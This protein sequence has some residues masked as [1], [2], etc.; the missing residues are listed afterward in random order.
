MTSSSV[1]SPPMAATLSPSP[2]PIFSPRESQSTSSFLS[3]AQASVLVGTVVTT[4]TIS[5]ICAFCVLYMTSRHGKLFQKQN[6]YHRLAFGLS[7][8]DLMFVAPMVF[9]PF[10]LPYNDDAEIEDDG[11]NGL[12]PP[13]PS[14]PWISKKYGSQQ[15]CTSFG[16]FTVI[17]VLLPAFYH[18]FLSFH[19]FLII[20]GDHRL[21]SRTPSSPTGMATAHSASTSPSSTSSGF[22]F[23]GPSSSIFFTTPNPTTTQSSA[24]TA[25]ATAT[26]TT[27]IASKQ[28][29][30]CL[31][32]NYRYN[33]RH[34]YVKELLLTHGVAWIVALCVGIAGL[35][36]QSY[37][38]YE[39]VCSLS[40]FPLGCLEQHQDDDIGGDVSEEYDSIAR[41]PSSCQ[42]GEANVNIAVVIIC[43]LF[44]LLVL[45]SL[46]TLAVYRGVKIRYKARQR[47]RERMSQ[48]QHASSGVV[49]RRRENRRQVTILQE[50]SKQAILY[51]VAYLNCFLAPGLLFALLTSM[52]SGAVDS[53]M[54]NADIFILHEALMILFSITGTLE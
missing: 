12:Q 24:V 41:V 7:L 17:G 8:S 23:G 16:F 32:W 29:W 45:S 54:G 3:Q 28:H 35:A 15:A 34:W 50:A 18:L 52:G 22:F 37:N 14:W 2:S 4:S 9:N 6:R 27:T 48:F 46:A 1:S 33:T 20:R 30:C 31:S 53:S 51:L 38:P 10:L 5:T 21:S 47:Y 40:E 36:T 44:M 43:I 25:N 49:V 42:R 26:T 11:V 13:P 39:Y 19:F